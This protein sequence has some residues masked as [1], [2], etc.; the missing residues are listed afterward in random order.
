MPI[1]IPRVLDD[2]N[3]YE[4]GIQSAVMTSPPVAGETFHAE[5]SRCCADIKLI[6]SLFEWTMFIVWSTT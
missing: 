2:M 4:T 6:K 5:V 3:A 1:V